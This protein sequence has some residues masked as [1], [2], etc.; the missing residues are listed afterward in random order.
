MEKPQNSQIVIGLHMAKLNQKQI[1]TLLELYKSGKSSVELSSIFGVTKE[2]ILYQLRAAGIERR[3]NSVQMP[4]AEICSRYQQGQSTIEIGVAA[5]CSHTA[6][7]RILRENGVALRSKADAN[8]KY[9]RK[10]ECVICGT[11]FRARDSWKSTR[12]GNRK[13]CSSGCALKLRSNIASETSFRHGQSQSYY[14]VRCG[15]LKKSVCE[16]CGGATRLEIHHIDRNHMNNTAG[17]IQT[18]CKSCHASVHYVEDD[19]GLRGWNP[20]ALS[21]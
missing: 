13:T 10:N 6:I 7:R 18:L 12:S 9:A 15:D 2:A 11:V 8:E 21:I 14:T 19:R 20:N 1:S 4:V 17:N 5:G 16:K 3:H